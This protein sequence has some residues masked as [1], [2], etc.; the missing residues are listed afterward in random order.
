[1]MKIALSFFSIV[2]LVSI[3]ALLLG[4][5][6]LYTSYSTFNVQANSIDRVEDIVHAAFA[7]A[8]YSHGDLHKKGIGRSYW[9]WVGDS[10]DKPIRYSFMVTYTTAQEQAV[11][12]VETTTAVSKYVSV[13]RKYLSEITALIDKRLKEANLKATVETQSSWV[14]MLKY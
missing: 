6:R 4:C 10:S 7:E 14:P 5:G 9:K 1:M 13:D 8:G 2:C 11:V 12:H 3:S